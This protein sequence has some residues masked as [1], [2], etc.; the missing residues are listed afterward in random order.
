MQSPAVQMPRSS[1]STTATGALAFLSAPDYEAPTDADGNNV[2]DVI[3]SASDSTVAPVTQ[4][5]TVTVTDVAE[6]PPST[7]SLFD[8]A[9]PVNAGVFNDGQ[10][11]SWA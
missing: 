2:Y 11:S 4:N 8:P 5:V 1:A 7:F 6:V 9:L 3:V 10:R